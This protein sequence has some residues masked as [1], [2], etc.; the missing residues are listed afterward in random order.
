MRKAIALTLALIIMLSLG[1][2]SQSDLP[3]S[4]S[5]GSTAP[6]VPAET[7]DS[8]FALRSDMKPPIMAVADFGFP[9][10]RTEADVMNYLLDEY[11]NWMKE[12]DFIRQIPSERFVRACSW[13]AWG[14]LLC[15]VPR[16]PMATVC[17]NLARWDNGV[18]V[19]EEVLY[20]SE[21]GEPILL[22][23]D[24]TEEALTTII[25]T[26][27][28]GRG[29]SWSPYLGYYEALPGGG[30]AGHL[31]M[32]FTPDSEKSPYELALRQ[33]WYIPT[34]GDLEGGFFLSALGYGLE[35]QPDAIAGDN[36]GTA[37]IYDVDA[38]G[39]LTESY[40]GSWSYEDELLYLS[41]IPLQ[42]D[43]VLIDDTFPVLLDPWGEG[44]LWIGRSASGIGLPHFMEELS[45]DELLLSAG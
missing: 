8:L 35:L 5:A 36:G 11:P 30:Y 12:M 20:R 2:C 7:V 14:Q 21:S 34:I 10:L 37:I 42:D 28:D 45:C 18:L 9:E 43:G 15:I 44:I 4:S 19:S 24:L 13:E 38:A 25:V 22:L 29:I 16:D 32:D 27:S 6:T 40:R 41:L 26:D 1:A 33:G 39:M 23:T 3:I 31:V 17:V